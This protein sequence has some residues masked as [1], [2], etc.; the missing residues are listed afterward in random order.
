MNAAKLVGLSTILALFLIPQIVV[1]QAIGEYGRT[2]EGVNQG[3]G[4]AV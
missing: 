4:S 2:L 3:Q 1:A